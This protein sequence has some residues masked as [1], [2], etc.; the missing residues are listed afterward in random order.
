MLANDIRILLTSTAR[1]GASVALCI[2]LGLPAMAAPFVPQHDTDVVET[3]PAGA[4][5]RGLRA[6]RAQLAR[7]PDDPKLALSAAQRYIERARATGD[8]RYLGH[9]Q[10]AL[11]KFWS[12]DDPQALLLRATILQSR[13][14][15]DA[16]AADLQRLLARSPNDAQAWLTLATIQQVQGRYADAMKSCARVAELIVGPVG[17]A[18]GDEVRSLTGD[19]SAAYRALRARAESMHAERGAGT[20]QGWTL[21][22]LAEMA[23]RMGL[24]SEAEQH[25][26][27]ALAAAP[28]L[29][30]RAAYADFLLDAKRP[31]DALAVL[32]AGNA[33]QAPDQEQLMRLSDGLLLRA[34]LALRALG[35]SR[36]SAVANALRE[37]F[38]AARLRGETSHGREEARFALVFDGDAQRAADLA[39]ANWQNQREPADA[40]IALEAAQAAGRKKLSAEIEQ[41][42]R[43]TGLRDERLS[44]L[45]ARPSA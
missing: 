9:A 27:A 17:Q 18:C 37:R 4:G 33:D 8:P 6:I 15:F 7:N 45:L 22:L 43:T 1:I 34:A 3:L 20:T 29:Y 38:A 44:R 21:T 32:G 5:D 35:D 39:A 26:R 36:T 25:Y 42:V 19:A 11:G 2:A 10:A 16:A 30:T 31:R 24:V 13:H 14:E 12:S 40:R 41:F 28:D 23:E